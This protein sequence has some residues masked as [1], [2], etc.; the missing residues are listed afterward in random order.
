M[1]FC[2]L[3]GG[4]SQAIS[5]QLPAA[6]AGQVRFYNIADSDFDRY[7]G[8]PSSAQ[9]QWM[10]AHYARMQT[11]SPYFDRRLAWYPNA[12]AYKNS[13]GIAVGSSIA[14]LHPEWILRDA[15]G[16]MLYMDWGC[17]G[18]SCPLYAADF[19]DPTYRNWWLHGARLLI[20]RRYKGLWVD[21]VNMDFRTSNGAGTPVLPIDPR[22]GRTMTLADWRRYMAE[23]MEL[24]RKNAPHAEIAHN[25]IWYAGSTSDVYIR[26]QI[27]AAD[28]I[29]LERGATDRG[30]VYGAGTWGFE[31]FLAYVD[32]VHARGRSVILMDYGT[33]ASDRE[34]ALASLFLVNG[35]RDMLAS[36]QLAW[37]APDTWWSGYDTYLGQSNGS[38]VKWQ[39]LLRRDFECGLVLANQP[40]AP[41]LTVALPG[42]YTTI[43]GTR[44]S[45]VTLQPRQARVLRGAC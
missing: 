34:F 28:Y 19:G 12:W 7:S 44:V 14:N 29:N 27:A 25:A 43:E 41:V 21:D 3:T 11:Y 2:A 16:N 22:T 37:T 10:R 4:S 5:G 6:P 15:N 20:A 40:G 32:F 42:I 9:Q 8:N 36:N 1:V 18:G 35:G 31:T 45:S 23:F 39:G 33:S 24:L 30:L 13:F 26:R 38:R 17:S